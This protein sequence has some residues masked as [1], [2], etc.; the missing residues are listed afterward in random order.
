MTELKPRRI[1]GAQAQADLESTQSRRKLLALALLVV[2]FVALIAKDWDFW[3]GADQSADA[4][5]APPAVAQSAPSTPAPRATT[6]ARPA[7]I[8]KR[9]TPV[10]AQAKPVDSSVVATNRAP[11]S[12]L[13]VE[14][15]AGDTHRMVS[16]GS[17]E[18]K[19]E[20]AR[21]ASASSSRTAE[22]TATLPAPTKAAEIERVSA[23]HPA[24]GSFDG[25]Y[26]LLAQQMRVQGSVVL[27]AL[28]G[29]DG[30]IQNLRVLN[31]PRILATAAQQAV[32]EWRFKPYFENGQAVETSARIT[33]NFTI[34]VADGT[35]TTASLNP[36]PLT[37][38]QLGE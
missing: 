10:A 36:P 23:L 2:A 4:E 32:R 6:A 34:N 3:F 22:L 24:L 31:G 21:P 5:L 27:Q 12:P 15:I 7:R 16:P 17:S 18:T 37:V 9:Q 26:P 29:A 14:V 25:S 35:T 1:A 38:I 33:V 20:L 30:L 28:I 19:V 13:S 11:V 8:A